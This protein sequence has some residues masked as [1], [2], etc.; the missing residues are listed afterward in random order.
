MV[1]KLNQ[2]NTFRKRLEQNQDKTAYEIALAM[3]EDDIVELNKKR[4]LFNLNEA[5]EHD[6]EQLNLIKYRINKQ[7]SLISK[8]EIR[9]N[10]I[11]ES[12]AELEQSKASIDLSQLRVLY[13]EVT[14]NVSDIH[15]TFEDLV[16]YH[17]RML[18]EKVKFISNELPELN[19]TYEFW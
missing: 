13:D 17:N 10:L 7:S 15:K 5:F 11:E 8:I 14:M 4:G 3:I 18:L 2:E 1:T 19:N 9:K 16:V 6:L 12:V